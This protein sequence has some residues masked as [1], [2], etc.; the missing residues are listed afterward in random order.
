MTDPHDQF[1]NPGPL[2]AIKW[3]DHDGQLVLITPLRVDKDV[4]KPDGDGVRDVIIADVA[5]L[6]GPDAP[7]YYAGT[8][9]FPAYLQGQLRRNVGT[10]RSCLGRV[11]KDTS[12]QQ[13]GQSAPWV[14]SDPTDADKHA[15][16]NYLA[17]Q[18]AHTITTGTPT[19]T[20]SAT[21]L[22]PPF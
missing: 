7:Q 14:L 8:P 10:G 4:P 12:R 17:N 15:A 9:I 21:T 11:G 2:N 6:D 20:G 16:R 18:A 22:N 3:V 13:R 19:S 1:D 5:V